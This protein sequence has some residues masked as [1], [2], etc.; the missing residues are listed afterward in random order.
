VTEKTPVAKHWGRFYMPGM[1]ASNL[2]A[3]GAR[4]SDAMVDAAALSMSTLAQD[5]ADDH[6]HLVVPVTQIDKI[7]TRTLFG[8]SAVQVDDIPDVVRRRRPVSVSYRK[9]YPLP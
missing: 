1:S 7:A 9:V 5:L 3:A 6:I 2:E 4:W 8:V